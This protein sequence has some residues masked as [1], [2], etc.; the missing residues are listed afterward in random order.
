MIAP[1]MPPKVEQVDPKPKLGPVL[2]LC[3]DLRDPP[4]IGGALLVLARAISVV[5]PQPALQELAPYLNLLGLPR[6]SDSSVAPLQSSQVSTG[7]T[8]CAI[9]LF[10][11]WPSLSPDD[12]AVMDLAQFLIDTLREPSCDLYEQ[13]APFLLAQVLEA[14]GTRLLRIARGHGNGSAPVE[15]K[16]ALPAGGSGSCFKSESSLLAA[17][18]RASG[19]DPEEGSE[20]PPVKVAASAAA[21][22]AAAAAVG[23][24]PAAPVSPASARAEDLLGLFPSLIRVVSSHPWQEEAQT[25]LQNSYTYFLLLRRRVSAALKV[26]QHPALPSPQTL[27]APALARA[28]FL[29]ACVMA[30]RG[31]PQRALRLA[32]LAMA[33]ARDYLQEGPTV[34]QPYVQVVC[35]KVYGSRNGQPTPPSRTSEHTSPDD[36]ALADDTEDV[37]PLSDKCN[38]FYMDVFLLVTALQIVTS[39]LPPPSLELNVSLEPIVNIVQPTTLEEVQRL[40]AGSALEYVFQVIVRR[41]VDTL[42]ASL[43]RLARA[44]YRIDLSTAAALLG[45]PESRVRECALKCAADGD[46]SCEI[47]VPAEKTQVRGSNDIAAPVSPSTGPGGQGAHSEVLVFTSAPGRSETA[48]TNQRRDTYGGEAV[49]DFETTLSFR[50]DVLHYAGRLAEVREA[51]LRAA[52]AEAQT[53]QVKELAEPESPPAEEEPYDDDADLFY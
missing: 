24:P 42:R 10:F 16:R 9:Y 46:L 48:S 41:G 40:A 26:L 15:R 5:G 17:E 27:S 11:N 23:E 21:A 2:S 29:R 44:Y 22:A 25:A 38:R 37:P 36:S 51:A 47:V 7:A 28:Y 13:A 39:S 33:Y 14:M 31:E 20:A 4:T 6:L 3:A 50:R 30:L 49:A 1:P 45:A 35:A 19:G 34:S 8:L 43:L 32:L 18:L 12:D 53:D 52:T